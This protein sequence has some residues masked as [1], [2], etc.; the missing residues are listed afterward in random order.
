MNSI[1]LGSGLLYIAAAKGYFAQEGVDV[2]LQPYTSGRD[3]LDATLE[4]RANLGTSAT[5]PVM[6]A[7]MGGQSV[8]VVA[9]I[10]TARRIH[11]IVARRDRGITTL[12]DLKGKTV[13]ATLRT[14]SHFA[15]G[16]MLALNRIS[17]SE[18][19]VENFQAENIV[20]ALKTGKVDAV[21]TW[22]PWITT[23]S[24]ALG[25]NGVVFRAENGF[26]S[27]F[28]LVGQADW[29][30]ANPE[31]TQRLLR[32][33]LR[34]KRFVDEKPQEAQ[35]ILVESMKM[36]RA[37]LDALG[38]NYHFVVQLD[39][40]LLITLEDQ[41]RWAIRNKLAEQTVIPNLLSVISMDALTAVSPDA[42]TIVR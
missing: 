36:D 35:D 14:D 15:F 31:K 7:V 32:A 34:S 12:A 20:E 23:A 26:V 6:F 2:T 10:F 21:S 16:S 24:K 13:G 37:S 11:G 42:V 9:T 5:L 4:K 8:S 19:R 25:A 22:E 27:E 28:S 29:I 40:N 3:A 41:A 33:L 38:T 39:Q 18:V 17:L 30:Q 1:Y